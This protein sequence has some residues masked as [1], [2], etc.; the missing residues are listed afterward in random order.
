M[1]IKIEDIG[2]EGLTVDE[3]LTMQVIGGW[4][5]G[6]AVYRPARAGCASATAELVG[7]DILVRGSV[8]AILSCACSR[9]LKETELCF[10][11]PFT[12]LYSERPAGVEE[13]D[14]GETGEHLYFA[15][16]LIELDDMVRDNLLLNL[17]MAPRCV[18][19][20]R[21]LCPSCGQNLNEAPCGCAG[22]AGPLAAALLNGI[23]NKGAKR[24][25][26]KTKKVPRPSR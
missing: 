13:G 2:P 18:E 17:P 4:L 23:A 11:V 24:G 21:G 8:T 9:C 5:S 3:P 7:Q 1:F 6:D 26:P 19:A 14:E 10:T 16:P 12:A 22:R 25:S 20:C 15:G